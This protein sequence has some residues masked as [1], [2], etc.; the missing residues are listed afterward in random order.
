MATKKKQKVSA[1]TET[2]SK[3]YA[4]K[5]AALYGALQEPR[6]YEGG[7]DCTDYTKKLMELTK[8]PA[9]FDLVN[10]MLFEAYQFGVES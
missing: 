9:I 10:E 3:V 2:D 4:E 7:L 5:Q 6:I 8:D 1:I